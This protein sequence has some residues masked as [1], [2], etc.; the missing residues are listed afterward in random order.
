MPTKKKKN[1]TGKEPCQIIINSEAPEESR[2]ALVK[3]GRLEA[4]DI[5]TVSHAQ[6]RGNLYKGRLQNI[7]NSLQAAFIDIGL[8]R[9]AYL[10]LEEIHPD[11]YGYVEDK[12]KIADFLKKGQEFLVQI[13]K[14]ETHVKGAFVTTYLSIPGRYLVL[15][16]GSKQVGVSRKIEDEAERNRLK[17][18]L[19]SCNV[20]EGVGLIARTAS[21]GIPKTQIQKDLRY[22]VR[23]WRNLKQKVKSAKAPALIYKDRDLVT[24]FLRDHLVSEVTEIIVDTRETYEKVRAFIKIIAPR[25]LATVKLYQGEEP[26]FSHFNLEHQIDQIYQS[27]VELPSGGY[28]VIEPTEALVSIDVNSGRNVKEKDIEDT[29]LKTNLEAAEEVARQLRLRDLGGI[30]VIDFIDMRTRSYR[31]QLERHMRECLKEDRARTEVARISRFGTLQVVRQ[32][33]RAPV[34]AGSY[35]SCPCC[36]GRGIVKSVEALSLQYLRLLV[37][38]LAGRRKGTF[39]TVRLRVPANV[40][41]YLLNKKRQEICRIEQDHGVN[42]QIDVDPSLAAEAYSLSSVKGP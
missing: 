10:P 32:K 24:R 4:F 19:K 27:R 21:K 9:N 30:I 12:R 18:I 15:M 41:C 34:Q 14:E 16:P 5:E 8:S 2:I 1:Q 29:A 33:I 11:Y 42:I 13:V 6:T 25:Q 22:L 35:N 36:G 26:I 7:E 40:A 39:D 17:Q 20:P 31:Q 38:H 23:L 37:G 3:K 28:I